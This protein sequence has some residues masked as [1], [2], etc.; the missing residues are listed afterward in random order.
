MSVRESSY[1]IWLNF[2]NYTPNNN[3]VRISYYIKGPVMGLL[4]DAQISQMTQGKKSLDELMRLLY[5]RYYKEQNRGFTE[6]EFWAACDEVAGQ[7]MDLMRHLVD[8]T[9]A[10]DYNKML[11]PVGLNWDGEK[12]T[13]IK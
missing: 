11:N 9:D 6:E 4:M 2:F 10:I 3:D 12:L 1:D 5:N 13:R 8:T 7:K